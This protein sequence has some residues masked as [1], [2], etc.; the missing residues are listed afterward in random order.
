[1]GLALEKQEHQQANSVSCHLHVAVQ[2]VKQHLALNIDTDVALDDL[3]AITQL[4]K[5]YVRK[6]FR[7]ATGLSPHAYQRQ[8]RL[9]YALTLLEQGTPPA[10]VA[11]AAGF[12]DQSHLNRQLKQRTGLTARQYQHRFASGGKVDVNDS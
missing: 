5:Y 7:Q 3:A 9:A 2:L 11:A 6:L 8:L 4:N 1:L 10:Q 12:A